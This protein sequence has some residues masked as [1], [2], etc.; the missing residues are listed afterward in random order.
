[1][2]ESDLQL[3]HLEDFGLH[4]AR[5]LKEWATRLKAKHAEMISLGYSEALYKAWQFYF[6]YCEGGF[7]EKSIGV[8][9]FLFLKP[10]SRKRTIMGKI[11]W[12]G[13]E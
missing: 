10:N 1:M 12:G 4:Y 13:E 5:T 2:K 7:R 3:V 8:S 6:S 11:S 9:Q